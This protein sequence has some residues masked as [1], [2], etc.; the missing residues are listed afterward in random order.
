MLEALCSRT[1]D[2]LIEEHFEPAVM[3]RVSG[4]WKQVRSEVELI[5][6]E[7]V[8]CCQMVIVF[9]AGLLK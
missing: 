6:L 2:L 9:E 5:L 8:S 1:G 4:L 7:L 3:K